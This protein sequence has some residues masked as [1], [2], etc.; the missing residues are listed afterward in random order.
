MKACAKIAHVFM[1]YFFRRKLLVGG[2]NWQS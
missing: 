2:I 1:A